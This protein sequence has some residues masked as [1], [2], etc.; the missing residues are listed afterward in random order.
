MNSSR[1][2]LCLALALFIA[3]G[4]AAGAQTQD[5]SA[6]AIWDQTLAEL[7]TG[8]RTLRADDREAVAA[9][10]VRLRALEDDVTGWL[11]QRGRPVDPAPQG[12]DLASVATGVSR[13]RALLA[14][15]HAA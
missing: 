3:A 5:A 2:S 8:V 14:Q 4:S 6:L 9:A 15:A 7:E 10:A 12:T 13:V 11:Q 1:S